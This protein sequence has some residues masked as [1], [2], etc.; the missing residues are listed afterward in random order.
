MVSN[1]LD[2]YCAAS[3]QR[4]NNEKSSIFFS[5]GCPPRLRETINNN[6]Q[7]HNESLSERYLGMPT[8]VGHS[9][10]GTFKYL[11]D[12]VWEKIK[13]WMAKLLSSAGKEVL[14]KA[15]AQAIPVYSMAC[16]R[17][18]RGLCESITSIICQFWWGSK[19]G[20]RKAAWVTWDTM[21][22]SKHL[23]GLGFRDMEIFNLALLARQ[24]WRMLTD[25]TS[26][27][28]RILKAIYF[29]DCPLLQAELGAHPSQIWRDVLDGRD[30]LSLGL[31]RRIGDG[32]TTHIWQDNWI[33][34]NSSKRPFTAPSP[35]APVCVAQL[36]D[37]T[38]ATW[39][40]ELVRAS[41]TQVDAE[42]ILRI[43]MCTRR[44]PDFWAW[45]EEARGRFTVRSAY[46]MI[47]R[48]KHAHEAQLD[49][50]GGTSYD[51]NETSKWTM[52][53]NI[54]VP[55]KLKVFVWRLAQQSMPTR[56]VLKHR[57]MA[58]EDTCAICGAVDTWKHALVLCPMAAS[59]WSLA[60]EELVDRMSEQGVDNP[61]DW[62]CNLHEILPKH[63]FDQM[64]VTLWAL[65]GVRRKAIH[66]NIF[67]SPISVN[68]FIIRYLSELQVVNNSVQRSCEVRQV[69]AI[70][71]SW[72]A[73]SSGN[74]K[75]NVHAAVSRNGSGAVGVM[76]RDDT[77]GFLG[78]ATLFF[79]HI[80]DPVTLEVLAIREAL[81]LAEDLY[82]LKIE[83]VLDCKVVVQD[84]SLD[85]SASY[86]AVVHEIIDRSSLFDFCSFSYESRS[87]NYEAHNLAKHALSLDDG[88]HVWLG[89][90]G[91]LPSVPVNIVKN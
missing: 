87:S 77:G 50:S 15:V 89:H 52:L 63:L 34:R 49:G 79:N 27:N 1:L 73:P 6:L 2:T 10:N 18:P 22:I 81:A 71:R 64:I 54:Q 56:T 85:N 45:H 88:R 48:I 65:W 84:L 83:I 57:H 24:A 47:L 4:I 60:S 14:I 70:R 75:L 26:L 58:T 43:P 8:D 9:K 3:G 72:I 25:S 61:K 5:K 78:A 46:R 82:L 90:P 19:Q 36:I 59:V 30:V 62:L 86:G 80:D 76:C 17:L 51:V 37:G 55:S 42:A 66:E 31:I 67:Q 23:G 69:Q 29:P 11:R 40:E 74:A 21:T 20:K 12:G 39:K 38:S 7:V 44:I 13:G 53:W 33:P 16:F 41:F 68:A 28:A 35:N 32:A 91:N